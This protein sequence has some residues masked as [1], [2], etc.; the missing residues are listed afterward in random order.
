MRCLTKVSPRLLDDWGR[1]NFS[2]E[3]RRD[4]LEIVEQ[5]HAR[6]SL[7]QNSYGLD[8]P[9]RQPDPRG[10]LA[11]SDRRTYHRRRRPRS[12]RP[13]RLPHRDHRRVPAQ[14]QQA[15]ASGRDLR[16][17]GLR[18]G[19]WA[20]IRL[21]KRAAAVQRGGASRRVRPGVEWKE[22]LAYARSRLARG[23]LPQPP[24]TS[25]PTSSQERTKKAP[26]RRSND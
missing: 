5:R 2:A 3:G 12:H 1:Q 8:A 25:A 10:A 16:E 18:P 9:D 17:P 14:A 11:G 21:L 24:T 23:Q 26:P 6:S 7:L 15:I 22:R 19:P 13:Q 4:L 20:P